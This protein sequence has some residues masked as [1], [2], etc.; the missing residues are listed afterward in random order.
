V[1]KTA[2]IVSSGLPHQAVILICSRLF[3]LTG[4]AAEPLKDIKDHRF[5][6]RAEKPPEDGVY[7]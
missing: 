5:F 3:Y 6:S 2:N 4:Y 1:L 7:F